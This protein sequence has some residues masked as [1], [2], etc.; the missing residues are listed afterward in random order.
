MFPL[1]IGFLRIIFTVTAEWNTGE[2]GDM[3]YIYIFSTSNIENDLCLKVK[4]QQ[5]SCHK[6]GPEDPDLERRG[7]LQKNSP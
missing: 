1:L 6:D 5:R 4:L 3:H 2:T 7:V